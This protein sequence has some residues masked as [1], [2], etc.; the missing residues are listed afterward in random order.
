[1]H[2]PCLWQEA[3]PCVERHHTEGLSSAQRNAVSQGTASVLSTHR[4]VCGIVPRQTKEKLRRRAGQ[5]HVRADAHT[6]PAHQDRRAL[7]PPFKIA[8]P[9][10]EKKKKILKPETH[11]TH[12]T[13]SSREDA[14]NVRYVKKVPTW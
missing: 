10:K 13:R 7:R 1:M 8:A 4:K 12:V 6:S 9:T 14:Q 5:R 2:S 11:C 3:T